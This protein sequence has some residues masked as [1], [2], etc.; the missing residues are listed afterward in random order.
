LPAVIR[1]VVSLVISLI[2]WILI[3]PLLRKVARRQRPPDSQTNE[4]TLT[5]KD[6]VCGM[7]MD[8]RL[9]IQSGGQYFCSEECRRRYT[10][11]SSK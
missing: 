9:A 1:F 3:G 5:V 11:T 7:Y 4:T 6:P 10:E 2:V 8:P